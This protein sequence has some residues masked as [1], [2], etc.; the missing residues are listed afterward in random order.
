MATKKSA[1]VAAPPIS[2]FQDFP[3]FD[4]PA[5]TF[6][7]FPP[8]D[9]DILSSDADDQDE[10]ECIVSSHD[11]DDDDDDCMDDDDGVDSSTASASK[12]Q[13]PQRPPFS[14]GDHV[15]QWCRIAG[16][17]AYHHHGIVMQVDYDSHEEEWML[18]IS[19]FSNTSLH[20]ESQQQ[21]S[22]SWMDSKSCIGSNNNNDRQGNW[23]SYASPAKKWNKVIYDATLWQNA[24]HLSPGTCTRSSC[25][26][27]QL[28]QARVRFLQLHSASLIE[29]KPYHWLHNNCESA[30][31][32]CK[33]GSWSTLQALS[34]LTTSVVGHAKSTALLASAAATA[35]V[36]VTAPAAG[37]MGTWFGVTTTTTTPLLVCQPYLIPAL[38]VY[39]LVTVGIPA[40]MIHNAKREWSAW[41]QQLND[42]FWTDYA[43]DR[44]EIFVECI[45]HEQ[46]KRRRNQRGELRDNTNYNNNNNG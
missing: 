37:I 13:P 25:D 9:R 18:H 41:T 26:P 27:P 14:P 24:T 3:P 33:T 36:T 15:Y 1:V 28:V 12:Q 5:S 40:I 16:I 2:M 34:F 44:P 21:R 32:W 17:P 7:D 35:E 29:N 46:K 43:L 20:D 38:A 10:D 30:A 45:V 4:P 23:R 39:G 8:F 19:D 6:Q 42:T 11:D 22:S 31:V